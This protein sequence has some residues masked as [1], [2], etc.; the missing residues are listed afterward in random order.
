M[1]QCPGF[2]L[3]PTWRS[4]GLQAESSGSSV[5]HLTHSVA[6]SLGNASGRK[7]GR[8]APSW[9]TRCL[10]EAH[11]NRWMQDASFL[12]PTV[13]LLQGVRSLLDRCSCC[14]YTTRQA[15]NRMQTRLR[16]RVR[17]LAH[18]GAGHRTRKA[19]VLEDNACKGQVLPDSAWVCKTCESSLNKMIL[20]F[21]AAL[22][23]QM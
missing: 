17:Q 20:H 11:A 18:I 5:L 7:I 9:K 2:A 3:H 13:Q 14:G 12:A 23:V 6:T 22:K 19:A 4:R 8:R 21:A 10:E 16:L 1:T 15:A